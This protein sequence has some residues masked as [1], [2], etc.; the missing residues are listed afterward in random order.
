MNDNEK[1]L[2]TRITSNNERIVC[3]HV[4]DQDLTDSLVGIIRHQENT[5]E[6]LVQEIKRHNDD[7]RQHSS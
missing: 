4:L 3:M 6:L 1:R 2:Y 7:L 5:I